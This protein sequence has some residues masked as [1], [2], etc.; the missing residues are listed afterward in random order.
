M[1]SALHVKHTKTFDSKAKPG[2]QGNDAMFG[3]S[4]NCFCDRTVK[5]KRNGN[6]P[7][8]NTNPLEQ[9]E[10]GLGDESDFGRNHVLVKRHVLGKAHSRQ[11]GHKKKK[12]GPRLIP[13]EPADKT[14]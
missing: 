2:S 1:H 7:K 4:F 12:R 9:L 5:K 11:L 14:G 3:S 10:Q 8:A 6:P 13:K